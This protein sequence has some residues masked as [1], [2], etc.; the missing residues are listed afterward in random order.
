MA[1]CDKVN[2]AFTC[3]FLGES[4]SIFRRLYHISRLYVV[5]S[6][7]LPSPSELTTLSL[8]AH[9]LPGAYSFAASSWSKARSVPS[10]RSRDKM[11]LLDHS[12]D[13]AIA[14]YEAGHTIIGA[15]RGGT[16]NRTVDGRI[17]PLGLIASALVCERIRD[18][19][20]ELFTKES[21]APTDAAG[22]AAYAGEPPAVTTSLRDIA[23]AEEKS[24]ASLDEVVVLGRSLTKPVRE[25]THLFEDVAAGIQP[26]SRGVSFMLD[27]DNEDERDALGDAR[28]FLQAILLYRRISSA[29]QPASPTP[30][31]TSTLFAG[32]TFSPF[33]GLS[34]SVS[35]RESSAGPGTPHDLNS[36]DERLSVASSVSAERL[37]M[38][39]G[40]ASAGSRLALRRILGS[41]TF[42]SPVEIN[43]ARDRIVDFLVD[44]T[45]P[46]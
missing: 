28:S 46:Q 21:P 11:I 7:S 34:E 37:H 13:D 33:N 14:L 27:A 23:G 15:G 12:L 38:S 36:D 2:L 16:G 43:D 30:S 40:K 45:W 35:S 32:S 26:A 17:N 24:G 4:L 3:G 29:T 44:T 6:V 20:S 18:E 39:F 1:I 8:I 5:L 42:A 10:S 19:A 41:S 9:S 31:E 25:L 22:P